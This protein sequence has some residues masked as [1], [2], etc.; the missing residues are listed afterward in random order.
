[1]VAMVAE[2]VCMDSLRPPKTSDTTAVAGEAPA[3]PLQVDLRRIFRAVDL[4]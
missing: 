1:M 4:A 2:A 3:A